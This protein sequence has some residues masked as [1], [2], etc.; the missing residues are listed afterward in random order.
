MRIGE[1]SSRTGASQRSLRYYEQQ[2]L[3]HAGRTA[4]GYRDYGED[5]VVRVDNVR[6]LLADGLTVDDVRT[7]L[8]CLDRD[9]AREPI[10]APA[11]EVYQ[12]RL[13]TVRRRRDDLDKVQTR[14]ASQLRHWGG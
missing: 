2:G 6:R 13:A 4:T 5:A 10:C 7:F 3:L 12:R 8:P 9:L 1:L 11:V 14:L